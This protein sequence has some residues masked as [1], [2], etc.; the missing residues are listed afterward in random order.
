[1]AGIHCH[2]LDS[3]LARLINKG[4]KV[5]I[6]EQLSP[7]GATK[8]LV[9]RDVVRVVTPGTVVEPELLEG[10]SNNYLCSVVVDGGEVGV[11]LSVGWLRG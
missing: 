10:K 1:M 9:E 3:Y 4:Y 7:V 5:T 2:A 8:G 6:C 11:A